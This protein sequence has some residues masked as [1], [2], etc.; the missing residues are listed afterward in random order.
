MH[1][2]VISFHESSDTI[3]QS[4]NN[5]LFDEQLATIFVLALGKYGRHPQ[6]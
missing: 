2:C 1:V 4:M 6:K 5:G 3:F